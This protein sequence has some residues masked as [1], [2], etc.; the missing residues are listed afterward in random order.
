MWWGRDTQWAHHDDWPGWS[1]H[2]YGQG[3]TWLHHADGQR[4]TWSRRDDGDLPSVAYSLN[5]LSPAR[6]STPRPMSRRSARRGWS[7]NARP[8]VE[9]GDYV[10]SLTVGQTRCVAYTAPPSVGGARITSIAQGTYLGPVGQWEQ[11]PAF[12]SVEIRGWWINIWASQPRPKLFATVV[13]TDTVAGWV[14]Q[15]WH[16]RELRRR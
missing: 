15:G 9:T 3:C 5:C 12:T 11:T 7:S 10:R 4:D 1:H 8:Q 13:P 14:T 16:H 2:A 6:G